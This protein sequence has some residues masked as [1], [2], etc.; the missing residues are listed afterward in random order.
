MKTYFVQ[1]VSKDEKRP[2]EA[3]YN[4]FVGKV[5]YS[6]EPLADPRY[7]SDDAEQNSQ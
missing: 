1:H 7:D 4:P 5:P 2:Y 3:L 6:F